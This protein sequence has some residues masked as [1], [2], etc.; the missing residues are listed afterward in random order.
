M[1][2]RIPIPVTIEKNGEKQ[3]FASMSE[4]GRF[5]GCQPASM[6]LQK[7]YKGWKITLHGERHSRE[8]LQCAVFM[9][10]LNGEYIMSFKSVHACARYFQTDVYNVWAALNNY[11]TGQGRGVFD[12]KFLLRYQKQNDDTFDPKDFI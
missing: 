3:E 1:A 9:F 7:T 12:K 10:K 8:S 6:A 2:K 5:F 11:N 4:A